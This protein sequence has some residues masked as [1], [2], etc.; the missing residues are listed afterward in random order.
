MNIKPSQLLK[1][2]FMIGAV[3]DTIVA[4]NWFAIAFGARIPNA[5]CFFEGSGTD[6]RFAMYIA[7]IIMAGWAV[8]LFWGGQKPAERKGLLLITASLILASIIFELLFFRHIL[9]G[10]GFLF[11]IALRV[12]L[13]AKFSTSYFYSL[14]YPDTDCLR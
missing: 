1:L 3:A 7:A 9:K 4:A 8:L 11:G 6:Y 10:T 13:I 14:K 2:S 12:L 5:L